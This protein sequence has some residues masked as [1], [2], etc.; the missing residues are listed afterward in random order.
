MSQSEP[1]LPE[2]DPVDIELVAYL[3]EELTPEERARIE[4]RLADDARYRTKLRHMQ[5]SWDMLDVLG[6]VDPDEGFTRTT[7]EMV[8]LK[9]K[10]DV[11]DETKSA[12]RLRLLFRLGVAAGALACA[13]LSYSL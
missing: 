5:Q 2:I 13:A 12:G 7:V 10:E 4:R 1:T 9:A 8:A 6:R 11:Q 3:D